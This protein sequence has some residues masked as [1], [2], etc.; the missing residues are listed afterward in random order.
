MIRISILFFLATS[1]ATKAPEDYPDPRVV[2]VGETG[3]GKSSLANALLGCDPRTNDCM[4]GVCGGLES[5]TNETMIGTG[6]WTGQQPEFTVVDTPG[7]G[8]SSGRDNTFIQEMMEVLDNQLGYSNV[9]VLA[10]DGGTPRFRDGLTDMLKQMSSIFGETWWDFMMVGVTKWSYKQSAIDERQDDCDFYGDPSDNCHNEAWFIREIQKQLL[11]KFGLSRNFTFAF[12]DS[13]S[14]S[15]NNPNDEVQQIHWQEETGKLW[16]EATGRNETF[17]FKTID[18]I[19]EEYAACTEENKRLHDIIDEELADINERVE[20]NNELISSL[21]SN[22]ILNT[23]HI[24]D[25]EQEL[26][27]TKQRV[28]NNE[29]AINENKIA[30]DENSVSIDETNILIDEIRTTVD[31]ITELP[32]GTITAWVTKVSDADDTV[33]LPEGWLRCDGATIPHPS[34]WAG[35]VT[36]DLNH[37]RR[38]LRGGVDADQ[39]KMEEDQLQDH[40]H[41]FT[42]PGHDHPYVDKWSSDRT[43]Q[44]GHYG[45]TGSDTHN[46]RFDNPNDQTTSKSSSGVKVTGVSSSYRSGDE[47]RPKNMNVIYI[48]R[49]F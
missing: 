34:I 47:T 5:C 16:K 44:E 41:E 43:N 40:M 8:D 30:I 10:V 20:H 3:C 36:P 13:F 33:D 1:F 27:T 23:K 38:F 15:G 14:Q 7:F 6:P 46:G 32:V 18:D 35:K 45:P 37:G 24:E 42:D 12:M 39:L 25:A 19:L 49:V 9:I 28:T 48:I 21:S 17:D 26:T 29:V 11:E 2:I 4:F 22:V 31:E